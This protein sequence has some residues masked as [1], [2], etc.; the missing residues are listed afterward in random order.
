MAMAIDYTVM[1]QRQNEVKERSRRTVEVEAPLSDDEKFQQRYALI[2]K[3][4]AE[5]AKLDK[6][7]AE[8]EI[9][10]AEVILQTQF[11]KFLGLVRTIVLLWAENLNDLDIRVAM[12]EFR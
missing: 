8:A 1:Q 12:L 9:R 3:A 2:D 4:K 10:K 6:I 11:A 7:N 5:Q